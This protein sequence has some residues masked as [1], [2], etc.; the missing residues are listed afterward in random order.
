MD[1]RHQKRRKIVQ[2]LFSRFFTENPRKP[3]NATITSIVKNVKTLDKYI[4]EFA[5]IHASDELA[6]IDLSILRLSVFE[7]LI[8]K[9]VPPKVIINEAVEL[10]KEFGSE[11]SPSFVNAIL[12]GLY[13]KYQ[14]KGKNDL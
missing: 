7:L 10:A 2:E 9:K 11:K 6:K 1:I 13:K 3:V 14:K 5:V 4:D 12:G 8:E